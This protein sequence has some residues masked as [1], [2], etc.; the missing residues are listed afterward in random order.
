MISSDRARHEVFQRQIQPVEEGTF[1]SV[2]FRVQEQI[3]ELRVSLRIEDRGKD[4]CTVDLGLIGPEGRLVGWSGGT[5]REIYVR[6]NDAT[7]GY[8]P[9]RLD[10][11]T[12]GVLLGAYELA[13]DGVTVTVDVTMYRAVLH[14][15]RGDLHV[16]SV[17][18]DGQ[19]RVY[20]LLDRAA[21]V[22]LDFL[23]ITDHN[24]KTQRTA[25]YGHPARLFVIPGMEWTSY[26][27][28]AGIFGDS[29]TDPDFRYSSKK[30][31]AQ[32]LQEFRGSG[33]LVVLNHFL[34]A[35]CPSCYWGWGFGVPYDAL[36]VWNGPWKESNHK[37]L[38]FWDRLL[39]K[40]TH[41]PVVGGSDF[42]R[43]H[44]QVKL[45]CPTTWV[46]T[47][48]SSVAGVLSGIATGRVSI[49]ATPDG[50]LVALTTSDHVQGDEVSPAELS[51]GVTVTVDSPREGDLI[52]VYSEIGCIWEERLGQ[53]EQVRTLL[54]FFRSEP[55]QRYLRAEVWREHVL[56]GKCGLALEALSNPMYVRQ[57]WDDSTDPKN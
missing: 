17:Q 7:P 36:E 54:L 22:G 6:E 3:D 27:G 57:N 18:S 38:A 10:P 16:H 23:C 14:W 2:P 39:R 50:P 55:P 35:S 31:V 53:A 13:D 19:L 48:A 25:G 40:G 49:S 11:G 42:H 43:D 51:R 8:Q 30:D 24:V 41:V 37:A 46:L 56:D 12:W 47:P 52:R 45:G 26:R 34:D 28:H 44:T 33:S 29:D 4:H 21:Q 9:R 32:K 1:I 20:E 15:V 5:R